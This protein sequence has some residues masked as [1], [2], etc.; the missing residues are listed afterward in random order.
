MHGG[1]GNPGTDRNGPRHPVRPM[2]RAASVVSCGSP[3]GG[4][5]QARKIR[6]TAQLFSGFF[7]GWK[8]RAHGRSRRA[9][10]L[11]IGRAVPKNV[12]RCEILSEIAPQRLVRAFVLFHWRCSSISAIREL[13]AEHSSSSAPLKGALQR[14]SDAF[15]Y[16]PSIA[17]SCLIAA[18]TNLGY[19]NATS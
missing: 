19:S 15:T 13:K 6:F 17:Q 12:S 1:V 7:A 14:L 16:I 10:W 5:G 11:P 18:S 2:C 9:S 3:H 4:P 8:A